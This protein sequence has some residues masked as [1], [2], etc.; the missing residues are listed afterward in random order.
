[1]FDRYKIDQRQ[2]ESLKVNPTYSMNNNTVESLVVK[3]IKVNLTT[4][5]STSCSIERK[6]NQTI[7]CSMIPF[8]S[9][10]LHKSD[11]AG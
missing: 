9:A 4:K 6:W 11:Q 7:L 5:D 2:N 10:Q 1:M 3:K 8:I